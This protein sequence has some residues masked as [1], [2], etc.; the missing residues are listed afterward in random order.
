M[1]R[2]MMPKAFARLAS[3]ATWAHAVRLVNFYGNVHVQ[4]RRLVTTGP[5]LRMSPSVS[6]RN[7][8][9]ITLGR[10]VH[11]GERSCLWAGDSNGRISLGDNALLG[12]EVFITASNY[13]VRA[14]TPVMYQDKDEA[15]VVIGA[16]VWLGVRVTV[17]PGVVIGDGA[18][19]GAGSV[20]TKS[21]PANCI[22]GGVPAK[23]I[24]WRPG[25]PQETSAGDG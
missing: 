17:L 24:G 18:I 5:G 14:G 4:Q 21:L 10:E 23:V 19:V 20:V 16:D 9:R 22:A 12:P 3:P 25:S 11:I 7:G 13:G 2:P 6:L 15:D 8:Q 1:T